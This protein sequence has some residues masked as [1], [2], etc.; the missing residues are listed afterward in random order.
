M[1]SAVVYIPQF[2]ALILGVPLI[3]LVAETED[4]F[5]G[6]GF[7]FVSA[8]ATKCS[9]KLILVQG[10]EQSLGFHQVCVNL[11][12]MSERTHTCIE[13]FHIAFHNEVPSVLFG[14]LVTELYH[15]LEFP[16]AVDMHQGKRNLARSKSLFCQAYHHAAVLTN[17][18]QHYRILKLCSHFTYDMYGFCLEFLQMT[19]TVFCHNDFI[20]FYDVLLLFY[21]LND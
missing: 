20:V 10:I 14:I 17:A 21:S 11:A 3:E 4:T 6:S 9:I 12:T 8:S 13:G 16:F 5:L 15:F 2:G 18:I 1:N 19:Q 7:F